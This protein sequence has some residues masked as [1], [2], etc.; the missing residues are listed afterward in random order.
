[1]LE[2]RVAATVKAE[3]GD[4]IGCH[5]VNSF[6]LLL[7]Q[8][9][10]KGVAD[11]LVNPV[12]T[13]GRQNMRNA[14]RYHRLECSRGQR[15]KTIAIAIGNNPAKAAGVHIKRGVNCPLRKVRFFSSRSTKSRSVRRG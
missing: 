3:I 6:R 15:N 1:M 8:L 13:Y 9:N 14:A 2:R 10:R 11:W 5:L 7:A 12:G 4:E